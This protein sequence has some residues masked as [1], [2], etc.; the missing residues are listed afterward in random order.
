MSVPISTVRAVIVPAKARVMCANSFSCWRRSRLALH[1]VDVG[2]GGRDVGL[3]DLGLGLS[4]IDVSVGDEL[5]LAELDV[6]DEVDLGQRGVGLVLRHRGDRLRELGLGLQE[7]LID[8]GDVDLGEQRPLVDLVAD[9]DQ[10][11]VDVAIGAR[12]DGRLLERHDAARQDAGMV[13]RDRLRRGHLDARAR[14]AGARGLGAEI[15]V[16]L[17]L[18]QVADHERGD[19]HHGEDADDRDGAGLRQLGRRGQLEAQVVVGMAG[20]LVLAVVLGVVVVILA[21]RR[22]TVLGVVVLVVLAMAVVVLA[23]LVFL[24]GFLAP[25]G[26]LAGSAVRRFVIHAVHLKHLPAQD[27]LWAVSCEG[28]YTSQ[29]R[30][31]GS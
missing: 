23:M 29:A 3:V 8:L 15:L 11:L 4:L 7:L 14:L 27:A 18:G 13:D 1:R 9:V 24:V 20:S 10:P 25:L 21:V 31:R 5:L 26:F 12:D 16:L 28:G 2:L 17:P 19:D 30:K 6:A 22:I